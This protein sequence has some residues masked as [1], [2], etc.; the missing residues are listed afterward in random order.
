MEEETTKP[1]KAN[2]RP[3]KYKEEYCSREY[4]QGYI[5]ECTE[6]EKLVSLCGY[7]CYIG[8][9][10][11]IMY[12]WANKHDAFRKSLDIIKQKSKE[13]LVNKG[14]NNDYNSTIAKLMLSHNHGMKERTDV[15]S[16]DESITIKLPEKM[17][18]I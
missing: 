11:K 16:N 2:G 12:D 8:T 5:D 10:E 3:T 15:T 17:K 7:S 1:K 6:E 9:C 14:L 13:M 18:D 4:I